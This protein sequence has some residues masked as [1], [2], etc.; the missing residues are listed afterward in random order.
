M[1]HHTLLIVVTLLAIATMF[2]GCKT[3][4]V[5]VAHP[6]AG[7]YVT[8]KFVSHDVEPPLNPATLASEP[9]RDSDLISL[10]TP[11]YAVRRLP[12]DPA[13]SFSTLDASSRR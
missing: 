1:R 9:A 2:T 6:M 5:A 4:E 11:S 12:V 8:A 7:I 10:T 13:G 3:A